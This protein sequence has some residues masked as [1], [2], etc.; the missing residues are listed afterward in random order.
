MLVLFDV[1]HRADVDG[2]REIA[3]LIG[4]IRRLSRCGMWTNASTPTVRPGPDSRQWLV[5]ATSDARGFGRS[6]SPGENRNSS[7]EL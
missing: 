6:R 3:A 5:E 7:R 1:T 4:L 2:A